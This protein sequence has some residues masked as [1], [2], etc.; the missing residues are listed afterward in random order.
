MTSTQRTNMIPVMIADLSNPFYYYITR[1]IQDI[2]L[3]RDYDVLISNTNHLYEYEQR[4]CE[5]MMRRPVDGIILV[6]YH[7]TNDAIDQLL[8]RT[9]AAITVLGRHID[10]PDVD[11]ISADDEAAILR[12]PSATTSSTKRVITRR[13]S[14]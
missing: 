11:I 5:A 1:T 6:P 14:S 10:H 3:E 4:F 12:S 7:L 8:H 2:A 13:V 9:G